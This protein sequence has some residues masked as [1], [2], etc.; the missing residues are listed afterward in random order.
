MAEK[1]QLG[2]LMTVLVSVA[3]DVDFS[4]FEKIALRFGLVKTNDK[5]LVNSI[6]YEYDADDLIGSWTELE[7]TIYDKYP[8]S[9]VVMDKGEVGQDDEDEFE[10]TYENLQV[11]I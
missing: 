3:S 5:S 4:E 11:T 1:P 7:N 10:Y 6:E 8:D 2:N 9:E